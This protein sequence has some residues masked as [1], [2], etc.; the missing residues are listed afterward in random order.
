[1][2]DGRGPGPGGSVLIFDIEMVSIGAKSTLPVVGPIIDMVDTSNPSHVMLL[3]FAFMYAASYLLGGGSGAGKMK[4]VDLA[5]VEGLETNPKVFFEVTIGGGTKQRIEFELFQSLV[6]KTVENFRCLCTGEKGVGK[7]GKPLHYKG[8]VFHRVI[9]SFMLQGGDFTR[10][11]GSG[12]ESIY[13]SKF[14]DEFENGYAPHSVPGL[15][16]MANAGPGTNGSQFF[17]TTAVTSWLDTKHV[18]FGKVT[19]GMDVVRTIERMGSQTGATKAT[20]T[21]VDS[22]EI[23]GKAT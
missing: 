12:G 17:V 19:S 21:I 14:A 7:S 4:K 20:I 5:T 1:M 6:P 18:V 23:K 10:G 3:L 22:G 15:L 9:P 8:S 2:Q 16:S 11:N 13:G